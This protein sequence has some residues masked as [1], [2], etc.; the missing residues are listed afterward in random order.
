MKVPIIQRSFSASSPFS[1]VVVVLNVSV[2]NLRRLEAEFTY[3]NF[4]I[5]TENNSLFTFIL[6][7]VFFGL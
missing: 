4:K 5:C 2:L 7:F 1:V 3:Y 6:Y